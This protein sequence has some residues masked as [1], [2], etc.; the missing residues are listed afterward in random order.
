MWHEMKL[1]REERV[2]DGVG[3]GFVQR[4]AA[5][6]IGRDFIVAVGAHRDVARGKPGLQPFA[7]RQADGGVRLVGAPAQSP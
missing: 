4:I 3:A 6:H 2:L 5:D 1:V 7:A